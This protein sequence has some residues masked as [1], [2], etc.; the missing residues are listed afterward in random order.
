MTKPASI[1]RITREERQAL[2]RKSDIRGWFYAPTLG[3]PKKKQVTL[4]APEPKTQTQVMPEDKAKDQEKRCNYI[5]WKDPAKKALLKEAALLVIQGEELTDTK[6]AI[7]PGSTLRRAVQ[8]FS[9]PKP[10][11]EKKERGL[12]SSLQREKLMDIVKA[13]DERN[14]GLARK[15]VIGLIVK[16]TNASYQSA[17]NHYDYLIRQNLLPELKK[18]GRVV[19]AQKTSTKRSNMNTEQQLRWHLIVDHLFSELLRLNPDEEY[20]PLSAHFVLNLDETCIMSNEGNLRVIGS[21]LKKKHE[22]RVDDLKKS[23]TV[24]RIGSA[25]GSTGPW[26]FLKE[27]KGKVTNKCLS[28]QQLEKNGAPVG[29]HV[30]NTPSAYLTN[31]SWLGLVPKLC[32]GI[33]AMPYIRDHP[34]WW[35]GMS[36]DGFSSHIV[37]VEALEIFA[38]YKILIVKEE[39]DCLHVNQAYDQF[40]AKADKAAIRESLDLVRSNYPGIIKPELLIRICVEALQQVKPEKWVESFKRVNLHPDFRVSFED[41]LRKIDTH[42]SCGNKFFV[43]RTTL[44]DAL[45]AV[46]TNLSI[47]DRQAVKFKLDAFHQKDEPWAKKNVLEIVK[48]V[49]LDEIVRL[50]AVYVLLKEDPSLMLDPEPIVD[51]KKT[52]VEDY[53][54]VKLMPKALLDMYK[55]HRHNEMVQERFFKHITNHAAITFGPKGKLKPSKH[56]QVEMTEL[57]DSMLNPTHEQLSLGALFVDTVGERALKKVAKRRQDIL[58]GNISS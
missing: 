28:P 25:G 58:T 1:K 30:V 14:D 8:Q 22:K 18:G 31:E 21:S 35:C 36:F 57:Q 9:N 4:P 54:G 43:G 29:S 39:G 48:W 33:R 45:P 47:E 24:I 7:I 23:V 27:G 52:K 55:K 26:I 50:R 17:E 34:D 46:W 5:N 3:R 38:E 53:A 42:L 19:S 11:A 56:L 49:P 41:W 15:E 44:H 40:V 13:R 51:L 32:R 10:E 16:L 6:F 37:V 2:K 20:K 12:L